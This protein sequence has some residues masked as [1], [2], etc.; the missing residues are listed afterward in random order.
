[1]AERR[2]RARRWAATR[3]QGR[4]R[5]A[6]SSS[7]AR[8]YSNSLR[9]GLGRRTRLIR[10]RAAT[11]TGTCRWT[12]LVTTARQQKIKSKTNSRLGQTKTMRVICRSLS[13]NCSMSTHRVDRVLTHWISSWQAAGKPAKTGA[14]WRI[15]QIWKMKS[16]FW[17]KC[18][19]QM[20]GTKWI[21]AGTRIQIGGSGQIT[22]TNLS[23]TLSIR[24]HHSTNLIKRILWIRA[25]VRI[26]ASP[27]MPW[28]K[29]TTCCATSLW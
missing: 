4:S 29:R 20:S 6:L 23:K 5:R 15:L 12:W 17:N 28:D 13:S 9:T 7:I 24:T 11:I 14:S 16:M 25:H 26:R 10:V 3:L 19:I 21:L 18:K 27:W 2:A 8:Y 22:T 1:M